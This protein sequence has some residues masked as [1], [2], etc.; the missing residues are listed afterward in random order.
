M[1]V[2]TLSEIAFSDFDTRSSLCH[3]PGVSHLDD[4]VYVEVAL[5]CEESLCPF[6][7]LSCMYLGI[8]C[9]CTICSKLLWLFFVWLSVWLYYRCPAQ[10]STL[11]L[12][13]LVWALERPIHGLAMTPICLLLRCTYSHWSLVEIS[14]VLWRLVM[15]ISFCALLNPNRYLN[16]WSLLYADAGTDRVSKCKF[17]ARLCH[18]G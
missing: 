10:F 5:C 3:W 2:N 16:A 12:R 4:D 15:R 6:C 18:F 13:N 9:T 7:V 1:R 17:F 11:Q 14:F 8:L